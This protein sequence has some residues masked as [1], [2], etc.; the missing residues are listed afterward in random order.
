M[1]EALLKIEKQFA[2]VHDTSMDL[3]FLGL[4]PPQFVKVQYSQEDYLRLCK[5][6]CPNRTMLMHDL[7][8]VN[9]SIV[10]FV[11]I[12]FMSYI[13]GVHSPGEAQCIYHEVMNEKT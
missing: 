2:E 12:S 7:H 8:V 13:P 11:T 1:Q 9:S 10:R 5:M 3:P 6:M 4:P